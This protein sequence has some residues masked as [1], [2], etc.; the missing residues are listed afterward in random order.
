MKTKNQKQFTLIELLVVIAIIAILAGMLLPALNSAREKARTISCLSNQKQIGQAFAFYTNSY[1]DMLPE[2]FDAS[3][4]VWAQKLTAE[5]AVAGK[6]F[7]CPGIQGGGNYE[8]NYVTQDFARRDP[9]NTIFWYPAYG[10]LC[11]YKWPRAGMN[12]AIMR[13]VSTA[14]K[15]S[16]SGLI[17]DVYVNFPPNLGH[18]YYYIQEYYNGTSNGELDARHQGVVNTLLLDGHVESVKT[19]A[20]GVAPFSSSSNPY[21]HPKFKMDFSN[22]VRGSFWIP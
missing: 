7:N 3:S 16:Q 13:K 20:R 15:P 12:E 2:I 10:M 5:G 14:K 17:A 11:W 4:V 1:S 22:M 9:N 6:L 8:W 19:D 18:A 21:M